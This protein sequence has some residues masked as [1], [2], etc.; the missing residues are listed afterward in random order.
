MQ[1]RQGSPHSPFFLQKNTEYVSIGQYRSRLVETSRE[2]CTDLTSQCLTQVNG[3]SALFLSVCIKTVIKTKQIKPLMGTGFFTGPFFL[4]VYFSVY[5]YICVHLHTLVY[6]VLYI[7]KHVVRKKREK[8]EGEAYEAVALQNFF[9][10]YLIFTYQSFFGWD[11]QT[12]SKMCLT[13]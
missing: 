6:S 9:N 5:T 13:Y 2:A 4:Q 8:K 1:S 12:G 7:F 3:V 10:Q 11:A